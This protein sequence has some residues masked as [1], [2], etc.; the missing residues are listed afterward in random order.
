MI[1]MILSMMAVTLFISMS[2]ILR[3]FLADSEEISLRLRFIKNDMVEY[4]EKTERKTGG[5][6]D[7][8]YE[9]RKSVSNFFGKLTPRAVLDDYDKRVHLAGRPFGMRG[10]DWIALHIFLAILL[11]AFT[12]F[13][14][15]KAEKNG[16]V[17]LWV[18]IE[19]LFGMGIPKFI[20][21]N[22]QKKRLSNIQEN[23]PSTL[24]LL[25]I[26]VEAG[27]SLDAAMHKVVTYMEGPISEEFDILLKEMKL[28]MSKTDAF[29]EL[30]KRVPI[31]DMKSF[32]RAMIQAEKTGS[33]IGNILKLISE[34]IRESKKMRLKEKI[35]KAVIKILIP[36]VIFIMP[37]TMIVIMGPVILKLIRMLYGTKIF[38]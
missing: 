3:L 17:L 1:Y 27:S 12:L 35:G 25:T 28:G 37:T 24:D 31:E 38:G 29:S 23:L 4:E 13:F 7:L 32:V 20:L 6:K 9:S 11:P 15:W 16:A 5:W 33:R 8:L 36:I 30:G 2:M 34:D 26:C 14:L 19:V 22:Q 21:A 10:V 18:C